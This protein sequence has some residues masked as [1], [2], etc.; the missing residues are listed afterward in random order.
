MLHSSSRGRAWRRFSIEQRRRVDEDKRLRRLL[1]QIDCPTPIIA[2]RHDRVACSRWY[3]RWPATC[4]LITR[5]DRHRPPDPGRRARP[6]AERGV[7]RADS[8]RPAA[9]PSTHDGIETSHAHLASPFS[10]PTTAVGR[11]GRLL[12]LPIQH[13][14]RTVA[15]STRLSSATADQITARS[16]ERLF[17][18]L[19]EL[20][21]G[22]AKLG[23]AMSVFEAAL[24]T[25]SPAPTARPCRG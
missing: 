20:K 17:A 4:R 14:A 3:R 11:T 12:G 23:Q 8:S 2:G 18:T 13:L 21:G 9:D 19:G 25:R 10:D 15:R 6:R 5:A 24:P 7:R 22:P 16:A 1:D